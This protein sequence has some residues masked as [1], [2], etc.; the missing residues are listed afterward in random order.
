MKLLLS[1]LS[2]MLLSHTALAYMNVEET[3]ATP[4]EQTSNL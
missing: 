2:F 3:Q 4:G 1:I